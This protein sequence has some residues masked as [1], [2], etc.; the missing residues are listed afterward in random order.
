MGDSTLQGFFIMWKVVWVPK[1]HPS[2]HLSILLDCFLSALFEG[3]RQMKAICMVWSSPHR[4]PTEPMNTNHVSLP[5]HGWWFLPWPYWACCQEPGHIIEP[6]SITQLLLDP[7]K[8]NQPLN[9]RGPTPSIN[10]RVMDHRCLHRHQK[11]SR[12]CGHMLQAARFRKRRLPLESQPVKESIFTPGQGQE[13]AET[14]GACLY[15]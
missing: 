14:V 2:I 9:A 8:G 12:W 7:L 4:V 10:V 6:G 11:N 1:S 3:L 15:S 13:E 5:W